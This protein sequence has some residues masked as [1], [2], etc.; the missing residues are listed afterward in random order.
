MA[1]VVVAHLCIRNDVVFTHMLVHNENVDGNVGCGGPLVKRSLVHLCSCSVPN[2]YF[3]G[4][5]GFILNHNRV[6][7]TV[8]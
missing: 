1:D 3:F 4:L 6:M 5:Y 8:D 7:T 2:I